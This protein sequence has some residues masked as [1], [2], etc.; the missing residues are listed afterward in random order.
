MQ[1]RLTRFFA[2]LG[3]AAT[4]ATAGCGSTSTGAAANV[5]TDLPAGSAVTPTA[6]LNG[7]PVQQIPVDGAPK[8]AVVLTHG[9]TQPV[10]VVA[11]INV[12]QRLRVQLP[13]NIL[14][15]LSG[16]DPNKS[17]EGINP[18]GYFSR[19]DGTCIWDFLADTAGTVQLSYSGGLVCAPNT[20]CPAIA[21]VAA[22][23]ITV[24]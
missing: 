1:Q 11:T 15:H 14:W 7:C 20:A 5:P 24:K 2:L 16:Q 4:L 23:S 8:A 3:C 13:A 9:G 18:F 6:S 22:F 19:V 17:M 10:P 21:A 12:G